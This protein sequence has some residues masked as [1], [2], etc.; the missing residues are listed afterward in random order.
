MLRLGQAGPALEHLRLIV[1]T[2]PEAEPAFVKALQG[3]GADDELATFLA[4]K[5]ETTAG[6]LAQ[7]DLIDDLLE[8]EGVPVYLLPFVERLAR[9]TGGD[10]LYT[11]AEL[12]QRAQQTP[13]LVSFLET[14]LKRST[15][16]RAD[17]EEQL[18]L[19]VQVSPDR[20][21]RTVEQLAQQ[22]PGQWSP[23]YIDLLQAAGD[24]QRMYAAIESRLASG[25]ASADVEALAFAL[26]DSGDVAASLSAA[27]LLAQEKGGDWLFTYAEIATKAGRQ[28]DLASFLATEIQRPD[29]PPAD[30]SRR[31]D[32]LVSAAPGQSY[33]VS[34]VRPGSAP[35]ALGSMSLLPQAAAP[36]NSV[37][38]SAGNLQAFDRWARPVG[39]P[40]ATIGM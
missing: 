38:S 36:S 39:Y 30:V 4:L 23:L 25:G 12:A 35:T 19:L 15:I 20:A 13:R 33:S 6:G 7:T 14:E 3:V 16:T 17:A 8:S 5:D 11:Y 10:W 40:T 9:D 26:L 28:A 37:T 1:T 32:L 31:V 27:R 21:L 2:L 18:S 22:A 34:T 24:T 29:L